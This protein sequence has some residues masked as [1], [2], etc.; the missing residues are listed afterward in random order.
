MIAKFRWV[1]EG[2][3][4]LSIPSD[5]SQ[6]IVHQRIDYRLCGTWVPAWGQ[7]ESWAGLGEPARRVADDYS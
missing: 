5:E 4:S 1:T 7:T 2:T 6:A 3:L